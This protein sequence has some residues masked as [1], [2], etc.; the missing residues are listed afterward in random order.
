VVFL[1]MK[2]IKRCLFCVLFTFLA[3]FLLGRGAYA[4]DRFVQFVS[5]TQSA[6]AQFEQKVFDRAGKLT[7]ESKGTLAF[8]RPGRFRWI[9]EK[10]FAQTIIGDG[11]RVWVYDP[12]LQ[13][14]T[15]KRV[16][17][18][19]TSTPAALLAGNNDV[20]R[21]FVFVDQGTANGLEWLEATPR[22][23]EGGFER[24]RLGFGFSGLDVMELSDSF[25]Q[26]TVLRFTSF[27]R[28]PSLDGSLFR[29][30]P[31]K[32]AD[33]IGDVPGAAGASKPAAK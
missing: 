18:V 28:N 6:R 3:M 4:S 20:T 21:S 14:V 17:Q 8:S 9:Y 31:P 30:V 13:Q 29:F 10:P 7:Q 24:V 33:V 5:T 1:K 22:E 23:K 2:M 11:V 15:V 25:G 12:D 32:G 19:M 27:E 16:T 26:K